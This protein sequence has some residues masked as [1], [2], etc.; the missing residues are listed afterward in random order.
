MFKKI[1]VIVLTSLL[2]LGL[3]FYAYRKYT[4]YYPFG[5]TG[6]A[7]SVPSAEEVSQGE[8]INNL[9]KSLPLENDNFTIETYDYSVGKF[10]V[11]LNGKL[12]AKQDDF[13][14]W[15]KT[16]QFLNI[17]TDYFELKTLY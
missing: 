10:K 3:S 11:T 9:I 16:S 12:N 1:T 8:A 2:I 7:L 14:N 6:A 5:G 4:Y 17:P 13:Y 15:L